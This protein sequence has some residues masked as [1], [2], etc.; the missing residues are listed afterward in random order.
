MDRNIG[1]L[2]ELPAH[3][4]FSQTPL[5]PCVYFYRSGV[6]LKFQIY[7][8][9]HSRVNHLHFKQKLFKKTPASPSAVAVAGEAGIAMEETLS[10]DKI[11]SSYTE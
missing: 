2:R 7:I 11:P 9:Q 5:E 10:F 1:I 6:I 8:K 3:Y 4:R